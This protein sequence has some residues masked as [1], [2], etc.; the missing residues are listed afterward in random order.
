MKKKLQTDLIDKEKKIES[1][2]NSLIETNEF[3]QAL[4]NINKLIFLNPNS[5]IQS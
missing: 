4:A 5:T 3:D 1:K 2:V